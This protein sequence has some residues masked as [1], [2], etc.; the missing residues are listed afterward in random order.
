MKNWLISLCLVLTL[1]ISACRGKGEPSPEPTPYPDAAPTPSLQLRTF[2]ALWSAVDENYVYGDLQGVDWSAVYDDFLPQV[3]A[4]LSADEFAETARAMLA[5]LPPGTAT[6]QTRAERIEEDLQETATYEGIGAYVAVR[7]TPEP[8]VVLLSVM[9]ESPAE[10][11]GL[12]AHDSILAIDGLPVR[13]EEGLDVVARIR[14]L[15]GS[16]VTLNVRSPGEPP[17][18]V[19][20]TRG[21]LAAADRLGYAFL[22]KGNVGY[23]LFPPA[24][25]EDLAGE[26]VASL[27]ALSTGRQ[28][29][30]LIL[31]LRISAVGG[32]WPLES[33]LT[34]F[35]DGDLGEFYTRTGV[36]AL[37]LK[38]QDY[39]NSQKLPLA[40]LVG[41]DTG[42]VAEIF[43]AATQAVGRATVVGLP[44]QGVIE[45][46]TEFSMPDG[47]RAFIH[48][49]SYRG[50]DGREIGLTGIEPDVRVNVDWDEVTTADDP[51]RDAAVEA[52]KSSGG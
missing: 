8:R 35:A 4:G 12:K 36:E 31:D 42:G 16:Q 49:S 7:A 9:K 6:W 18:D 39:L 2:E 24:T 10:G 30:G 47:S 26:V 25:Y 46:M 23:L 51:V 48:T 14:G 32:G 5:E 21:R 22:S 52:L 27:Q 38:G 33:L 20:V 29:D 13:A 17:R 37:T 3:Q 50:P 1:L 45:G 41:P 34:L 43:A 15:A 28:L 19:V 11:A 40:V 44:T